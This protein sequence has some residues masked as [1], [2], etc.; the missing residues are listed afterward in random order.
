[1]PTRERIRHE[2]Q[3]RRTTV[4][5]V[6]PLNDSMVRVTVADESLL[7]FDAPGPTDHVKLFF[8]DPETGRLT[9]PEVTA[10]GLKRPTDGVILSRDFTPLVYREE[11][12]SG[13]PELDIDFVRH[14][15]DGPATAFA[16]SVKPGDLLGVAGPRGSKLAPE[17]ISRVVL[18]ADETALPAFTRWLDLLP[19]G[20]KV[21]AIVLV[22]DEDAET[23]LTD[24]HRSRTNIEMLYREDGPG[25]L[26]E[27]VRSLGPLDA[28]T[29]VW[30][31]GEASELVPVRRYLRRDLGL[32]K[33]QAEVE[34][35]WKRGIVNLD[36]HA[37]LDPSD[38]D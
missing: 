13:L 23:Y 31:A 26:L 10:E 17:G 22:N 7:G 8:P 34:G 18:I 1:M 20:V 5:S 28:D 2:L 24:E 14:G 12:A 16:S 25:Q 19:T 37:P 29:Y 27:A 33:E 4:Q 3:I 36:H 38:P 32:G 11:N 21:T 6:T 15:D 35:Y 9:T 30:A